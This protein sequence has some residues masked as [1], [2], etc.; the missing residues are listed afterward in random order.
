MGGRAPETSPV[1]T[2]CPVLRLPT[3]KLLLLQPF[4]P[5]ILQDAYSEIAYLFAEFFRDLDIVPS[6]IIAG[7]VLLRQRQRAKRNAV[8]DEVGKPGN[9][10]SQL[11]WDSLG[12]SCLAL[13]TS[14]L[15]SLRWERKIMAISAAFPEFFPVVFPFQRA[16][17]VLSQ[18]W[19]DL[20]LAGEAPPR[21][22]S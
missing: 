17:L 7:L 13:P 10:A 22:S 5:W 20:L 9:F 3:P 19:N 8:L 16:Q 18:I 15:G 12:N 21:G 14:F 4:S 1:L 2:W 6:D 11:L